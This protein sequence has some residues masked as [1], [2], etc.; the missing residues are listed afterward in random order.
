[1]SKLGDKLSNLGQ[2]APLRLGF[3]HSQE[4]QRNPVILIVGLADGTGKA[5]S[6]SDLADVTL[7]RARKGG[8]PAAVKPNGN[9]T[10]GAALSDCTAEDLD[11]LKE[12]GCDFILIESESAPGITLR[13]DG[14]ARGLVVPAAAAVTD[15]RAHAIEDLPLDFLLIRDPAVEWPLTVGQI[16]ALQEEV[17]TFSKHIF[18]EIGDLPSPADLELLRDM[19]VSGLVV[20]IA[21]HDPARLEE[22]RKAIAGLEPRKPRSEHV[23]ILPAN[24]MS[25]APGHSHEPDPDGGDDGDDDDM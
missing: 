1:M 6:H 20:D 10:W 4:R 3:G 16:L 17:S 12:S 21:A 14:F 11:T 7:F 2:A 19:P 23:A 22:L 18:L 5:A 8:R 15:A 25:G 9:R 13:E 24:M